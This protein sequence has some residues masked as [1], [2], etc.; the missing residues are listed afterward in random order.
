MPPFCNSTKGTH[1]GERSR[2][3]IEDGDEEE[4][5]KEEEMREKESEKR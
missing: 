2:E 1:R 5:K 4:K 3:D